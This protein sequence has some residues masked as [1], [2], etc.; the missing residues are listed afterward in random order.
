MVKAQDGVQRFTNSTVTVAAGGGTLATVFST[1]NL[2]LDSPL[3]GTGNV[4]VSAVPAGT[5]LASGQVILN[6]GGNTISGSFTIITN[7]NLAL[8]GPAGLSNSVSI[9]VQLGGVLD[10]TGRTNVPAT[11]ALL[12]GQTLKGNGVVR[13]NITMNSG[14]TLAPGASI[15]TLSISN[16]AT[17]V[18]L[19]G[20]T[21]MEI[22]RASTP[23]ADRLIST[24]NV[25]GGTI[26]V[27]NIGGTLAVNDTFTLFTST[28]NRAAFA[29]TNL[30]ALSAG[31][32]WSNALSLNG[33]IKVI[34]TA[35]DLAV[36]KNGPATVL[37]AAS[38]SYTIIATNQ[39]A[40]L[41]SS[42][43]VTDTIP[44]GL[45]F[46]SASGG[47]VNNG[48]VVSWALGTLNPAQ[49]SNLT[50]TVT[51]PLFGS[52]TNRAIVSSATPDF[53]LAN[54][55]N[56]P[57]ITV[58]TPSSTI[59]LLTNSVSGS[60]LT[61]SWPVDHTGWR[62]QVQTNSLATGL[63]GNWSTVSGSTTVNSVSVTI[64]PV[65]DS[66]FYRMVYP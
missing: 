10:V 6:N 18:T 34:A 60:L 51:A 58:V 47:G 7:A 56:A 14:S 50:L 21:V 33:T 24:T 40:L 5:N 22:N 39:S 42:V 62:L 63:S 35:T 64:N 25:F 12:S 57:V 1:K 43:V 23:N 17:T 59:P 54:N 4:T 41:A 8:V 3:I 20:T 53:N 44:A 52:M 31:L 49:G 30:P 38:F 13:G 15:G 11:L 55:T 2:I 37:P 45:T 26:T 27:T 29:V 48:G 61:L 66:V 9:D 46:V 16:A 19:N 36:T 28:T 65:N 32:G